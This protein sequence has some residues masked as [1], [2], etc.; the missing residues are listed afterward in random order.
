MA[1]W[2]WYSYNCQR[3][4]KGLPQIGIAALTVSAG[5][6][7]FTTYVGL[8]EIVG[9]DDVRFGSDTR[10]WLVI[11]WLSIGPVFDF[12]LSLALRRQSGRRDHRFDVSE[13]GTDNRGSD[14]HQPRP[15]IPRRC[16]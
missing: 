6:I 14:R 15:L 2:V 8:A 16:I 3:W 12:H 1:I 4:L 11:A 10:E 7:G 9:F 5:T 13:P